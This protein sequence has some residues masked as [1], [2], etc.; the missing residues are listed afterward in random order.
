MK[1]LD[2]WAPIRFDWTGPSP[3]VEWCYLGDLRFIEPFFESTMQRAI[4]HPFRVLF[5]RQTPVEVLEERA[6]T[7]PGIEPTGFIF[8]MSRCGSTLIS[9]MM[10]A[11]SENVVVSEGWPVESALSADLR[12]PGVT[13]KQRV[14]WFRGVI[15]A[16]GQPRLGDEH[17]YFVKFDAPHAIDLPLVRTAF[18]NVPWIFVYRD[19]IE[20]LISQMNHP[21]PWT[22]PG[23]TTIRG[24][25]L[26]HDALMDQEGYVATVLATI[27]EAALAQA[28]EFGMLINY[29]QLPAAVFGGIPSHFHCS[30]SREELALMRE[31]ARRD[32]KSPSRQF[33]SDSDAKQRAA[34][35]ILREVSDRLLGSIYARLE[36]RGQRAG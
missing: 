8:H 24:V 11:S 10:A 23:A 22:I 9:Q 7:H 25:P 27:C 12:M 2:G 32:A 15:R 36:L 30:W 3:Q 14:S 18:P 17:R 34:D 21:A 13:W 5:R 33:Q 6:V 19:P 4:Q 20:V 26:T 29:R 35:A 28:D 31:A 16:L 1:G